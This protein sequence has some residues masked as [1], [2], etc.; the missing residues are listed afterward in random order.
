MVQHPKYAA[1]LRRRRIG[2]TLEGDGAVR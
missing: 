2:D 1:G